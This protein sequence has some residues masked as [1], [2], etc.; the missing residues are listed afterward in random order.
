VDSKSYE[1]THKWKS[2]TSSDRKLAAY[3]E[4]NS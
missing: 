2:G 4:Q 1:L 3:A